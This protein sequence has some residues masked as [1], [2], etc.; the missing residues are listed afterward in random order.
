M[1]AIS[2]VVPEAIRISRSYDAGLLDDPDRLVRTHTTR[3]R[4]SIMALRPNQFRAISRFHRRNRMSNWQ[5]MMHR[6]TNTGRPLA[7]PVRALSERNSVGSDAVRG[8]PVCNQ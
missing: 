6:R 4:A 8:H 5:N 1:P 2:V 7:Q 3:Q